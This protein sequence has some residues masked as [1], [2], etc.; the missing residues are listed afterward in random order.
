MRLSKRGGSSDKKKKLAAMD[1]EAGSTERIDRR[2]VSRKLTALVRSTR[3]RESIPVFATR[4]I[5]AARYTVN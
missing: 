3:V 1:Y 4:A 2:F 5:V